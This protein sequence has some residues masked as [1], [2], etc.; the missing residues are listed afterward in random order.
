MNER[1]ESLI[2]SLKL[3]PH[4]EG[5][6]YRETYR[7][8]RTLNSGALGEEYEGERAVVTAILYLLPTGARSALHRVRSDEVWMHHQGDPV[9]LTIREEIGAL[10]LREIRLGQG[11]GQAFQAVVEGGLW[12]EATALIGPSG[13]ALVGCVVAPGFDFEDFEMHDGPDGHGE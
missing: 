6:F 4:P 3:K 10:P 8:K 9:R 12:Q 2:Q 5:G 7:S 1:V 13:Y 11:A